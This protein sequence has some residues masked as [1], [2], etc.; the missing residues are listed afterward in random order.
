MNEI[1]KAYEEQQKRILLFNSRKS[2]E[3]KDNIKPV[4]KKF[5][6]SKEI[7]KEEYNQLIKYY[8]GTDLK[9]FLKYNIYVSCKYNHMNDKEKQLHNIII[10]SCFIYSY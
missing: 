8:I 5:L 7:S 1:N 10:K 4:V 3:E 6:A 9:D 2:Q